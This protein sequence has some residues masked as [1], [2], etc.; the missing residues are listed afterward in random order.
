M[1]EGLLVGHLGL[2]CMLHFELLSFY[3][4]SVI[5]RFLLLVCAFISLSYVIC[6]LGGC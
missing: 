4:N 5:F 3:C 1:A 6:G 2:L